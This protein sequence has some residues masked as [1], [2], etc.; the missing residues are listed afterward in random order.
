M[1]KK[2]GQHQQ[3]YNEAAPKQNKMQCQ[4]EKKKN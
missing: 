2:P 3:K 4:K 1:K